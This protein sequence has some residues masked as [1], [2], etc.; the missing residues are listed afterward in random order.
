[1]IMGEENEYVC[2]SCREA[3]CNSNKNYMEMMLERYG[4]E[5]LSRK[6]TSESIDDYI[7]KEKQK[8]RREKIKQILE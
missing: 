8:Q 5:S 6:S 4:I 2:D 7:R 3:M 1:M